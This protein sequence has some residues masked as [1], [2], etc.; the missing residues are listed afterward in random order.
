MPSVSVFG[1]FDVFMLSAMWY[2]CRVFVQTVSQKDPGNVLVLIKYIKKEKHVCLDL[3]HI[4][5]S[6][7]LKQLTICEGK[8]TMFC[9]IVFFWVITTSSP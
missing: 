8:Q 7:L 9:D 6:R 4:F 1:C 2:P 3:W 5:Y